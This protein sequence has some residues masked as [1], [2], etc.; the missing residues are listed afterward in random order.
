MARPALMIG[1]GEVLWD[2]LPSGKMLGGAPANFAYTTNVL[3]NEG[4]VASRVGDDE[5]GREACR[6]MQELG[7]NTS[8]VQRDDQHETGTAKVS[9]DAAGQPNFT[10]KESVSWD[11][12][13]WTAA[14][15]EL[16]A[17][18]DVV[19]FGSLAQRSATSAVTIDRFL[20]NA[21][22]K[23]LRICDVNLRQSFYDKDV[24]RKSFQY[25]DIV[26]LNE[27][28]LLEVSFLLKLGIGSEETLA[29]RLLSECHLRLVCVTRGALGSL[30]VSENQTVEHPGHRVNVADAVGAGDAFTACL[31]H[32]YLRAHSLEEISESANRFASWV[33]T[34][35]G[36]T[37]PIGADQL[38]NILNGVALPSTAPACRN[39]M[40]EHSIKQ[41]NDDKEEG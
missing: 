40:G 5:L 10:I 8:Y 31:A 4:I 25:A 14:W 29:K 6:V 28:E 41:W 26:K 1:L 27:H 11:F 2:L 34:Q 24:L 36:A 23:A 9:I 19:C 33:V 38:Q 35:R 21:P 16:S 30:L 18:A 15:E 37:P 13:Q 22:K 20:H 7:L 12:L 17:R 3:G 39:A 32:H